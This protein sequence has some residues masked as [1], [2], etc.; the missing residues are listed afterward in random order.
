MTKPAENLLLVN[1]LFGQLLHRIV[2]EVVKQIQPQLTEMESRIQQKIL[3]IDFNTRLMA[4]EETISYGYLT[5]TGVKSIIEAALENYDPT[6]HYGFERAV[7]GCVDDYSLSEK[8]KD[9][10]SDMD[11]QVTVR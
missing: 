9:T 1:D 3:D 10:I 4:I 11:F 5:T 6:N 8:I 7:E 2:T